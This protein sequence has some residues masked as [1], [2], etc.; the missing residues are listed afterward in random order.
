MKQ[1][2]DVMGM[3]CA[4]CQAHVDKSV[5]GVEGVNECQVNLLSETMEVDYDETVT[6]TDQIIKAVQKG[7]YDAALQ[8]V[9]KVQSSS[10]RKDEDLEKRLRDLIISFVFMIPLF[11]LSM[12]SMMGWPFIPSIFL[13]HENMMIF[14][15]TELLLCS[16]VVIINRHYFIGGFK[17]LAHLAPNMDSLI[18]IGSGASIVYSLYGM[19]M[20]AY[21]MGRLDLMQA[22]AYHMNLY[23]ESAAMILTLISL[24]KYFEARS[25]KKT[26]DAING[27][28]ALSPEEAV[29]L[30]NDQEMTVPIAS[31]Q[32]GDLVVVKSG[33]SIAV[34]GEIVEGHTT[35]D[36]SMITGE[37]I[38][39]DKQVGDL[40]IGATINQSGRIVVKTMKTSEQSTLSQIIHL[41]ED[42]GNSK[43]PIARLAD[44]ISGYFVPVVIGIA[45]VTLIAWMILGESFH[46]A[47]TMAIAVLVIS[48]P[49]ALGLATPT[50]IMVG[51][52]V[53]G[54]MGLLIRDAEALEGASRID[55]I[56]FDKT[57]T[58]TLGV[59]VVT[60]WAINDED[61]D[62]ILNLESQS[63]HPLA[64]AIA[65]AQPYSQLQISDY[66]EITGGGLKGVI[67]GKTVIVGNKRLMERYHIEVTAHDDYASQGKTVLYGA[68]DGHYAG[69]M[70]LRDDIKAEAPEVIKQLHQRGIQTLMLTGDNKRTAE[71]VAQ[72]LGM[73]VKAEV[74]P[75]DKESVIADLQSQ[76]FKVA[77]TGDGIN[78]APALM[79]ADL[80]ISFTHGLDIAIDSSDLVL[81]KNNLLDIV[82]AI[83]LSHAT[84]RNIKQNLFWALF[85]NT[86]CIPVAAGLFY[87]SFGLKLSPMLGSLAMSFSSVFVVTNALRLR[88][89]KP[90]EYEVKTKETTPVLDVKEK[91]ALYDYDV[92]VGGMMCEH[93][94]ARVAKALNDLEQVTAEVDL[95]SGHAS[96]KAPEHYNDQLKAAIEAAGYEVITIE[97]GND[98]FGKKTSKTV[99][100]EGM[101][102]VHCAAHVKEALESIDGVTAEV[103]LEEKKADIVMK[104]KV[105][106]DVIIKAV[107]DA[108]YKVTGIN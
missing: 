9:E 105:N 34:D 53:A 4:A 60:D 26:S 11:Y 79:R 65:R 81:M 29:V 72:E 6:S 77:M 58:L 41:V 93:C 10:S 73:E 75:Q 21:Y 98:M 42:A 47:L 8:G 68:V 2:F 101:M 12:G 33:E 51:T 17:S 107:A 49:C 106:D 66:E 56:V 90:V 28:M 24:G 16:V 39:V 18:A 108:G 78:D 102:C 71:A 14:A 44:V 103:S 30:K 46:F 32:I 97:G 37:S 48:C 92:T 74:L 89:F 23:F 99:M 54:K 64:E 96:V 62:Y 38:P 20:M 40:V 57:G 104:K 27:L 50:A 31:I 5:R 43:A 86:I 76:G 69:V 88:F 85:Y 87:K 67:N 80:G 59:P 45:L 25:K 83:D 63:S 3:T 82:N 55:M 35:V 52:G 13:G 15:L 84:M 95:E 22:H 94:Q 36:E 7:G 1:K 19:F 61:A 100:I 91:V 70:A